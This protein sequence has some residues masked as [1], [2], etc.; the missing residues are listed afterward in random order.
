[1]KRVETCNTST[2][3]E[4][5]ELDGTTETEAETEKPIDRETHRG[6]PIENLR[7][8]EPETQRCRDLNQG[9]GDTSTAR[10]REGSCVR[11]VKG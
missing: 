1:M 9:E 5:W 10:G 8:T 11:T 2:S 4:E 6:K 3:P 7:T